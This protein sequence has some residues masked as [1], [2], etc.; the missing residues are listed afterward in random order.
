MNNSVFFSADGLTST[1][2]NHVANLAK[3]YYQ[4]IEREIVHPQ[5]YDTIVKSLESKEKNY[6]SH[7]KNITYLASI[8]AKL[9]EISQAKSLIAWLRE[10]LKAKDELINKVNKMCLEDYL[11]LV[12]KEMPAN[13]TYEE[14]VTREQ[15]IDE[16]PIKERNRYFQLETLCAVIGK[17]I[18]PDGDFSVARKSLKDKIANPAQLAGSTTQSLFYQYVPTVESEDLENTFF[19][20]QNLHRETQAELNSI[21]YK[22]EKAVTESEI[23]VNSENNLKA[24]KHRDEIMFLNEELSEYKKAQAAELSKLKIVIPNSLSQIYEKVTALGKE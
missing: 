7:G 21:K 12:G 23:K 22:I 24:K 9:E 4:N 15:L 13:P 5:F 2:A 19:N 14:P 6:L 16:L 18:H 10:A 1:S 17:F 8:K 20:L 3:E 11:T